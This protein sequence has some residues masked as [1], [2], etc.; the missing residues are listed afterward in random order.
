M[1]HY[2]WILPLIAI[3][4]IGVALFWIIPAEEALEDN[5]PYIAIEELKRENS[6]LL[7][8]NG[9]LEEKVA[10]LN[11]RADSLSVLIKNDEKYIEHLK[12]QRYEKVKDIDKYT[13]DELYW[14]FTNFTTQATAHPR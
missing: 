12:A 5:K 7:E 13:D 11:Q 8:H 2:R 14:Y 3:V 4:S 10:L 1:K 9:V 6:T